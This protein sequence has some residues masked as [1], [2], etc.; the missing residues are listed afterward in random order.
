MKNKK[1][2]KKRL[3]KFI[4]ISIILVISIILFYQIY[5]LSKKSKEDLEQAR[6]QLQIEQEEQKQRQ[7]ER[8][9][10]QEEK[11]RQ[12]K[13]RYEEMKASLPSKFNMR[14]KIKITAEYQGHKPFCSLY[15]YIKSIEI[16]LNYQGNYNYDFKKVYNYLK[17]APDDLI[18]MHNGKSLLKKLIGL[19]NCDH[20]YYS[21]SDP[22]DLTI[23]KNEIINGRPISLDIDEEL[24]L[25]IGGAGSINNS[26]HRLIVIGYDDT[27]QS[28]LCLNSWGA[29]WGS[30]GNGTVWIKYNNKGIQ[31]SY[32]SVLQAT[33][34]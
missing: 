1:S 23:L 14:D 13:E 12:E 19:D 34:E 22:E 28:W 15:T 16:T 7:L 9:A 8:Q 4:I 6:I 2:N 27:K 20:K 25:K 10:Q 30:N 11:E 21:L 31:N 18:E 32:K 24:S 5:Q 29:T 17:T 3:T 26:G 33:I